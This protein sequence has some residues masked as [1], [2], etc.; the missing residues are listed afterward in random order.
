MGE[1][2][3]LQFFYVVPSMGLF[4]DHLQGSILFRQWWSRGSVEGTMCTQVS[5]LLYSA[6][7]Y[8]VVDFRIPKLH[9]SYILLKHELGLFRS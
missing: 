4:F 3:T 2:A 6:H 9:I 1:Q 8:T 5:I 7:S